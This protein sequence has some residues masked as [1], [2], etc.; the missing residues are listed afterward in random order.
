MDALT[1]KSYLEYE[2]LSR[3][4]QFPYYYHKFDNKYMMGTTAWL[5]T[6]VEYVLVK[7]KPTDTLMSLS[8]TYYGR[9]DYYWV[10]ADFNR[11]LDAFE[12][13]S[14]YHTTIKIPS[15]SQITFTN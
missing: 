7:V 13:L 9:P 1:D 12:N 5:N 14:E 6:D 11:I 2:N 10:I 4:A 8:N 15:I 3:Y